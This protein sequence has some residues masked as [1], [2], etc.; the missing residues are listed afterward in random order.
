MADKLSKRK[1]AREWLLLIG[2]L[3]FGFV[4]F[5]AIFYAV[6]SVIAPPSESYALGKFYS[7]IFKEL[8]KANLL[9]WIFVLGP[10]AFVQLVRSIIWAISVLRDK[11]ATKES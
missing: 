10:Y 2:M 9:A 7:E 4:A 11:P 8:S 6:G 3:V 1:I 5:P